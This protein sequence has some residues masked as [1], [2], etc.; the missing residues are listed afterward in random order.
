MQ[1]RFEHPMDAGTCDEHKPPARKCAS[2]NDCGFVCDDG[3]PM[4]YWACPDPTCQD[5]RR[6]CPDCELGL[7]AKG[8][9]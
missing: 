4:P 3:K 6:P 8:V 5:N 9:G 2:C 7:R 1:P